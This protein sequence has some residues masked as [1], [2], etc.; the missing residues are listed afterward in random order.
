[1][2]FPATIATNA[3]LIVAADNKSSSLAVNLTSGDTTLV[4]VSS[5]VFVSYEAV[6]I[7]S[8]IILL[9]TVAGAIATGC[10]RGYASTLAA[11]HVVGDVVQ[12]LVIAS[13][14]N[15]LKNEV[16]NIENALNPIRYSAESFQF[17]LAPGVSLTAGVSAVVP[18]SPFPLGITATSAGTHKLRIVDAVSG[19]ETVTITSVVVGA[20]ITFTPTITH[21]SANYTI[22]SGSGGIQEAIKVVESLP[23]GGQVQLASGNTFIYGTIRLAGIPYVRIQGCGAGP[24]NLIVDV[25]FT[26]G[27]VFYCNAVTQ[28]LQFAS[29]Q[30]GAYPQ[31]ASGFGIHIGPLSNG[32]CRIFDVIMIGT[33][34]GIFLEDADYTM[35]SQFTYDQG[36]NQNAVYGL[37]ISKGSSITI[38]RCFI[39]GEHPPYTLPLAGLLKYG[40]WIDEVDG[41]TISQVHLRADV[42]LQIRGLNGVQSGTVLFADSIIDTCRQKAI[43]IDSTGVPTIFGNF[44]FTG[45][46]IVASVEAGTDLI[47]IESSQG[48]G[49]VSFVN[50]FIAGAQNDGIYVLNAK[51]LNI[52]NNLI[53]DNNNS[54]GPAGSG[55]RIINGDMVTIVD[56][57]VFDQRGG[58]AKQR[59]GLV[60]GG[61]VSNLR[62][63]GNLYKGNVAAALLNSA[64]LTQSLVEG[65]KIYEGAVASAAS[66][67][68]N[69]YMPGLLIIS[70]V[71]TIDNIL[72]F[73]GGGHVLFIR[74][75]SALTFSTAGNIST[76]VTTTAGQFLTARYNGSTSKWDIG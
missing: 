24:T 5:G 62:E 23:N 22:I 13:H 54:T 29:F 52:S 27:D 9:G 26:A 12:D 18:L 33:A 11:T 53:A 60:L 10:T 43:V 75:I 72:G 45:N 76:A 17:V 66:I 38:S 69:S 37:K 30:L 14:H 64:T 1:M 50:N 68:I 49:Y 55:I 3:D 56:N 44:T 36:A 57:Q 41:V 61:N 21:S 7:G 8:E 65:T 2:A 31:H 15:N 25:S 70:G 46:H 73:T 20:S 51:Y 32:Q 48:T 35:V 16:I 6:V 28:T 4:F 39:V 71:T 67:T 59:Y 19:G 74:T 63:S 58:S 47:Y 34:N 42:G 40:I